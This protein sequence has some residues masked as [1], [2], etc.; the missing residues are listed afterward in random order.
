[1]LSLA[2]AFKSS[3]H[4]FSSSS[5]QLATSPHWSRSKF[6]G[7]LSKTCAGTL[8]MAADLRFRPQGPT[9]GFGWQPK[10]PPAGFPNLPWC[11]LPTTLA[12]PAP[13][14]LAANK[15][16]ATVSPIA[17]AP[18]G[19]GFLRPPRPVRP[20]REGP[21]PG[22]REDASRPPGLVRRGAPVPPPP[23]IAPA[24]LLPLLLLMGLLPG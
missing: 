9:H 22:R 14:A 4:V 21:L 11:C 13:K 16:A 19:P 8:D 17:A 3:R 7:I 1:M 24:P 18:A 2:L 23:M 5:Q 6:I 10:Q 15:P 20:P 12:I